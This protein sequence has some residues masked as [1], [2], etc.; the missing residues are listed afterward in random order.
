MKR[1]SR[2]QEMRSVWFRGKDLLKRSFQYSNSG[3]LLRIRLRRAWG[4][5]EALAGSTEGHPWRPSTMTVAHM[6][7]KGKAAQ[8][9]SQ[10]Q[11]P[12]DT[13]NTGQFQR[14][15]WEE[16]HSLQTGI[17]SV[18]YSWTQRLNTGLSGIQAFKRQCK[19]RGKSSGAVLLAQ[20]ICIL[21][22]IQMMKRAGEPRV[23]EDLIPQMITRPFQLDYALYKQKSGLDCSPLSEN[24]TQPSAFSTIKIYCFW[25]REGI[26][27][28]GDSAL[29]RHSG[30]RCEC[31]SWPDKSNQVNG[32][33]APFYDLGNQTCR[34]LTGKKDSFF[35][36]QG[37]AGAQLPR[38]SL[39]TT[40]VDSKWEMDS[41]K[42]Q[43]RVLEPMPTTVPWLLALKTRSKT[44]K[45]NKIGCIIGGQKFPENSR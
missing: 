22:G 15:S 25:R 44:N 40:E 19:P 27:P 21:S 26:S 41:I 12:K 3:G 18:N 23:R 42:S 9:P 8:G 34:L 28:F 10:T 43:T 11:Q 2:K 6:R 37:T 36:E 7:L 20:N 4:R 14:H 29:I 17:S 1:C 5:R 30:S 39:D 24:H 38:Q 35:T 45:Q 16:N 31:F 13:E 32:M 33:A